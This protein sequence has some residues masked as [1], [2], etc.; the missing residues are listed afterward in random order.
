MLSEVDWFTPMA[1]N[2]I[3]SHDSVSS[4]DHFLLTFKFLALKEVKIRESLDLEERS[5]KSGEISDEKAEG[6]EERV[7]RE[8]TASL[9]HVN[10]DMQDQMLGSAVDAGLRKIR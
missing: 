7:K 6:E 2:T 10:L 8:S 1:W 5:E 9:L 4:L 3:V